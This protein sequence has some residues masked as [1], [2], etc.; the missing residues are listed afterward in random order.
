M[1]LFIVSLTTGKQTLRVAVVAL[2]Y[3]PLQPVFIDALKTQFVKPAET[4]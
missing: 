1:F 4:N 2:Q 3:D